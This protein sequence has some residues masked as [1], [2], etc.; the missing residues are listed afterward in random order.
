MKRIALIAGTLLA[1]GVAAIGGWMLYHEQIADP[2]YSPSIAR[3]SH[4]GRTPVV[5]IDEGHAN[6]HQLG[7]RF[8]PFAKLARHGGY[9]VESFEDEISPETLAMDVLVIANATEPLEAVEVDHLLGWVGQGGALLL[10]ADHAPFAGPVKDLAAR[11]GVGM[12]NGFVVTGPPDG[13][14][15][16]LDFRGDRLGDHPIIAGRGEDRRV[17][18]VRSFTGQ[19]LTAPQGAAVLLELPEGAMEFVDRD[20]GDVYAKGGAAGADVSDRAQAVAFTLGQGRVVISGEAALF[21]AQRLRGDA[22]FKMGVAQAD[23]EA[24]V[25]NILDWLSGRDI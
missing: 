22:S 8:A 5:A 23:N 11:L 16:K 2:D 12:G 9:L 6:F 24:F 19:S 4:S 21:T 18:H 15:G 7:G 13:I 25:L 3:A 17:S 14:T 20:A 1:L 10:I